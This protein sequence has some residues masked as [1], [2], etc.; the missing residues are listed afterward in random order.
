LEYW[1]FLNVTKDKTCLIHEMNELEGSIHWTIM[2]ECDNKVYYTGI[3]FERVEMVFK[4][5][6]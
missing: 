2:I 1:Q 4:E 3:D 5:L 6:E